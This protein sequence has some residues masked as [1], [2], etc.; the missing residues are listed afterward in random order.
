MDYSFETT[1][2]NVMFPTYT[3]AFSYDVSSQYARSGY[4]DDPYLPQP[5]STP[6]PYI[7][8]ELPETSVSW[9]Q[10]TPIH[11]E[12]VHE[13]MGM[14][15]V[16]FHRGTLTSVHEIDE[17]SWRTH[18]PGVNASLPTVH[19]SALVRTKQSDREEILNWQTAEDDFAIPLGAPRCLV[20][21]CFV[22]W[23]GPSSLKKNED[24]EKRR[25][26]SG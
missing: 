4:I 16:Q 6:Q 7:K 18:E 22:D 26:T 10:L 21:F 9:H 13:T 8:S 24:H 25:S 12:I 14:E 11:T 2:I 23:N 1:S 15:R 17:L 3:G 19:P 5:P 20:E